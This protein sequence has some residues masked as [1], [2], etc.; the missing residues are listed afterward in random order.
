[1]EPKFLIFWAVF[2]TGVPVGAFLCLRFPVLRYAALGL[3]IWSTAEPD[4]VGINFLSREFYRAMT[5]GIEVSLADLCAL[6]LFFS[7]IFDK[8]IKLYWVPPASIL[9]L[10]YIGIAI[11]S[12]TMAVESLPVSEA[13][14]YIPYARFET[15]LFPLFEISKMI[16]GFL[17]FWLVANLARDPQAVRT[18]VWALA[19]TTLYLTWIVL[20][21]RYLYG[22]NR[23]QATLGH[24]NTLATYMALMATLLFSFA[25]ASRQWLRSFLFHLFPAGCAALC[26]LLTISRGGLMAMAAGMGLSF[27]LLY[28]RNISLKNSLL[29]VLGA[30]LGAVMLA[31]AADTLA[32]RFLGEQDAEADLEY[33]GKY[34]AQA[35]L[36]AE[37]HL[38]GVGPGNFS[39]WSFERYAEIVD[40]DLP[41]GTPPHNLWFLTLGELGWPGLIVF[42]L[43]W[44]RLYQIGIPFALFQKSSLY[45]TAACAALAASLAGQLQNALQLGY[46]QSPLFFL[47][48]ICMGLII[49][50][51]WVHRDA[52]KAN[53]ELPQT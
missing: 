46:R 47:N 6:A 4:L 30:T 1:M 21:D 28:V 8:R 9:Y 39:A 32:H 48:H 16:R 22:V 26:V 43:F 2:L 25:V 3:M 41:P 44:L 51:W 14:T 29:V 45:H 19:V 13:A 5:R 49:A 33:R 31:L 38:F 34:N 23:V 35:R 36:M 18:I 12:W 24:P 15:T 17:V 42:I 11:L 52:R 40:E 10:I 37:D 50:A 27:L 20:R 7:L 53:A